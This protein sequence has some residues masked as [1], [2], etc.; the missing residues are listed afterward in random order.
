MKNERFHIPVLKKEVIEI[1]DPKPNENFI[2]CT[3][4]EGGHT[5][6]ILGKNKPEGKVLGIEWD[7]KLYK[8][9]KEE[10]LKQKERL[11]LINDSYTNLKK[12]VKQK[13]F[14]KVQGIL[15]DLGLSSWHLEKSGRGFSFQKDEPLDMRYSVPDFQ[16]PKKS[17]SELT[18]EEIINKFSE[19][20]I[21]EI[22]RKYGEE[23][24]ARTI[25]REIIK[26]RGK[27]PIKTTVQLVEVIKRA[28]PFRHQRRIPGRKTPGFQRG[29]HFATRTF[30]ALRI[31]V[32]KE[33][34]NLKTVLPQAIEVLKPGGKI[35]VISFHS[36]EDRI[37]KNFLKN[38]AR[39]NY[40]EILTKK[41][42]RPTKEEIK[43][44]R[45]SRSAKLRAATKLCSTQ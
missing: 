10:H 26:E 23:R 36:L 12:I 30:Q 15:F 45:R 35:V 43:K 19:K 3:I 27:K 17:L 42:I 37:I 21:E 16:R 14:G 6:A 7:P 24:F 20:E 2:D 5:L 4:G 32:N 8:K 9:L 13:R 41:P 29:K 38:Q 34:N 25:A 39:D 1:L 28:I 40:L 22:L 31:F 33:L 44:N 11:I 18:A